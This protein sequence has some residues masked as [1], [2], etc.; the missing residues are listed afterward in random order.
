MYRWPGVKQGT[1]ALEW[2]R[3]GH[4]QLLHVWE[5]KGYAEMLE[6]QGAS[7]PGCFKRT[8]VWAHLMDMDAERLEKT[9]R[10][11][12]VRNVVVSSRGGRNQHVDLCGRP[13]EK[14]IAEATPWP[15]EGEPEWTGSQQE[16]KFQ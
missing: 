1:E 12:G 9:A 16:L 14:A 2:M 10:R 11:L 6:N 4:G 15:K 5:P 3:E 7:V 13:L 8:V